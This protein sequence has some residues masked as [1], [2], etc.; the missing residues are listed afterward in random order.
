MNTFFCVKQQGNLIG[1]RLFIPLAGDICN[2][3]IRLQVRKP[4]IQ[5][6]KI[7]SKIWIAHN[8]KTELK[9]NSNGVVLKC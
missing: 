9:L 6:N 3:E 2:N 7:I 5:Q 1:S 4:N 8:A